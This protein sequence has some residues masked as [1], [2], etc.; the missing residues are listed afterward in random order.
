MLLVFLAAQLVKNPPTMQETWVQFL[1]WED[2][3]EE[4]MQPIPVLLPG[5]SPWTEAPGRLQ[6]M[7]SQR[8]GHD[9]TTKHTQHNTCFSP[10][11]AENVL[12][13]EDCALN[14]ISGEYCYLNH[15]MIITKALPFIH[16]R[17]NKQLC[18]IYQH[19]K[20]W[21]TTHPCRHLTWLLEKLIIATKTLSPY[22]NPYL[23]RANELIYWQ[24]VAET[25]FLVQILARLLSIGISC[26]VVT[27]LLPAPISSTVKW[28][29]K[30]LLCHE[31]STRT[32]L[33]Q[34]EK[35]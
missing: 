9:W 35:C 27:W 7:G 6:S 14:S 33:D 10:H 20:W 23:R 15:E 26:K 3:L 13:I 5:E 16:Q 11:S 18:G 2:T 28:R 21:Q 32:I 8:I 30:K 25:W 12:E 31:V 1:G 29:W 4:G 24:Q 34:E 19:V 17:G 22:I